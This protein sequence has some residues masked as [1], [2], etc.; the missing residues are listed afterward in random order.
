[1]H[2]K[3]FDN[4]Q[5]EEQS[6]EEVLLE[7]ANEFAHRRSLRTKHRIMKNKHHKNVLNSLDSL[8]ERYDD[9]I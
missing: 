4:Q 8:N 1:V 5:A 7:E 6:P 3:I 2:L 9:N